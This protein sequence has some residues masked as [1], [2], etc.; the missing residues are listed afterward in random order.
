MTRTGPGD[1]LPAG[2]PARSLV[3]VAAADPQIGAVTAGILRAAGFEVVE[4][5]GAAAAAVCRARPGAVAAVLMDARL[6]DLGG[7]D[8]LAAIR[9][10]APSARCFVMSGNPGA[11]CWESLARAGAE[12]MFARPFDTPVLLAALADA[13]AGGADEEPRSS[14]PA[15]REVR[16]DGGA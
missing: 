15:D 6:P 10:A 9:A 13:V 11:Y 1:S 5:D 3:L 4:A 2:R 14:R 12:R 16:A 7:P 8:A